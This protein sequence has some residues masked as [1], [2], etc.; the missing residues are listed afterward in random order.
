MDSPSNLLTKTRRA[1]RHFDPVQS[2]YHEV[3]VTGKGVMQYILVLYSKH[4][5]GQ[6]YWSHAL[7]DS[8]PQLGLDVNE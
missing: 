4:E 5:L 8:T 7:T 1:L 3:N 2:H 6:K